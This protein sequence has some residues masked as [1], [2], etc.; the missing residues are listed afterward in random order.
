[1]IGKYI[2]SVNLDYR[3]RLIEEGEAYPFNLLLLADETMD[4]INK[5]IG[6]SDVFILEEGEAQL[7]VFCL[8]PIDASTLELK[9][10]AVCESLQGQGIG[11]L[12]IQEVVAISK[13]RGY[14]RLIV[15][16]ADCGIDQI[17]FYERNGFK[18]YGVKENFFLDNYAVPIIENG[19]QL[20]DMVML[21]QIL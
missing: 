2:R 13:K 18:K 5:Y 9:N 16:T 20:K 17:R 19:I 8:Y 14:S 10:I 1:M 15:G 4:A 7:A 3:L 11:G 21:E 12:L 6:D